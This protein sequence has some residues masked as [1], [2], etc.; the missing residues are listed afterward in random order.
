M[1]W[2]VRGTTNKKDSVTVGW[3]PA[4]KEEKGTHCPTSSL[5]MF[6]LSAEQSRRSALQSD[7]L[8]CHVLSS[9]VPLT[10]GL[11]LQFRSQRFLRDFTPFCSHSQPRFPTDLSPR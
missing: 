11:L 5:R 9:L 4:R 10:P 7:S 2:R 8:P 6:V 3:R 1:P